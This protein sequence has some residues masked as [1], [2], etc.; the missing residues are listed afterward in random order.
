MV[1][2]LLRSSTGILSSSPSNVMSN[3]A[4][5][6]SQTSS[7]RMLFNPKPCRAA[8]LVGSSVPCELDGAPK[9]EP[10]CP[11]PPVKAP[12]VAQ[13]TLSMSAFF[14]ANGG[15]YGKDFSSFFF[16]RSAR[17][18]CRRSRPLNDDD[19]GLGGAGAKEYRDE[20]AFGS[21]GL[22]LLDAEDRG[23]LCSSAILSFNLFFC[24][25]RK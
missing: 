23:K 8:G 16:S 6:K 15:A 9:S 13:S 7:G 12:P 20:G 2:S 24:R 22:E 19:A 3:F 11:A 10:A 21:R 4:F 18:P 14:G 25:D 1:T 17:P 5:K